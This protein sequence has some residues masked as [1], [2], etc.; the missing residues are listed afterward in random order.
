MSST[1]GLV[2]GVDPGAGGAIALLDHTC[3]LQDVA[4][5]PTV[6]VGGRRRVS[7]QEFAAILA[8]WT[9]ALAIIER[10]GPMPKQGVAGMFAFGY[11]AGVLEGAF[12]AA[13]ISVL[14]VAPITWK[15]GMGVTANKG[16][17]RQA[18]QRMW[19]KHSSEFSRARDD[20]RAEAALIGAY[21][22]MQG[23]AFG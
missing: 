1:S 8:K 6:E 10:V 23:K 7:A 14:F 3:E 21:H 22:I 2:V 12:A 13:G 19:P 17:S 15:R 4:D 16:S 5:M 9:P 11:S 18:A 20:G